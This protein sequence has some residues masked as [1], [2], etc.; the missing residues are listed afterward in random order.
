[1]PLKPIYGKSPLTALHSLALR[2]GQV[3]VNNEKL[4][5]LYA[6]LNASGKEHP[7]AW[8]SA[9][10]MA[11]LLT[12][13]PMEE[14]AAKW[15]L[16]CADAQ[17]ENGALNGSMVDAVEAACAMLAVYEYRPDR[18]LLEKLMRWC[19]W[20]DANWDAV[21]AERGIRTNAADL[22]E[23][24]MNL[25]RITGKKGLLKLL[26]QLRQEGM[27]WSSVLHTF[28]VQRPMKRSIRYAE[29]QAGMQE[30]KHHEAGFYT[31]Q[32]LTCH[33]ESLAD[34]ARAALNSSVY[35]GNGQEASAVK[36]GW[37]KINRWHGAVCGGVT[38]E[39]TLGSQSP[40]APV[41]AA[42]L[43]AWAETFAAQLQQ[44]TS[45]WAGDALERIVY[46]GMPAAVNGDKLIPFQRVNGLKTNCGT[47]DCYSVHEGDEQ[48]VRALVRLSRGWTAA[49]YAAVCSSD[50][51]MDI[52]L[53]QNGVYALQLGGAS[54]RVKITGEN[55]AYD[56]ALSMKEKTE[57]AVSIRVPAWTKD[58]FININDEGGYEGKPNQ[59]LSLE[60]T[61]QD[62][63]IIH[64]R[65]ARSVE[66]AE[67][68]H[69][70]VSVRWGE[71][72]MACPVT[73]ENWQLALAGEIAERDGVVYAQ[74][75]HV[76]SWKAVYGVPADLPVLPEASGEI[77][78]VAM[79]PYAETL[80]RLSVLPRAQKA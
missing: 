47:R 38:A 64:V 8:K 16:A 52:N 15:I 76:P 25:Y 36:N 11:C 68:Y 60:R 1:M 61:W 56:I 35:S 39:E 45:A 54:V 34:G 66:V 41:D 29:L 28:S 4:N 80:C 72:V 42:A 44:D 43:G 26:G 63:D 21:I 78:E 3:R 51:G 27:D 17:Q 30:E 37:E 67:G 14:N 33:G 32:Y 49:A 59:Y 77:F 13:K 20:V 53:F 23:L 48:A 19:A 65:F 50:K 70:S 40:A 62:G 58:A 18:A 46:N 31:R 69:Q 71:T 9:F 22:A 55:G 74:V 57:A 6:M 24:L 12:A 10:R 2:P 79:Q 5:A 7:A 75:K 73:E